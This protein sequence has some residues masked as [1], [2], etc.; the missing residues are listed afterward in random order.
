MM[1]REF[2]ENSSSSSNIIAG[3]TVSTSGLVVCVIISTK[4]QFSDQFRAKNISQLIK[5]I[6]RPLLSCLNALMELSF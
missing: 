5:G 4:T 6:S 1:V 3:I 2:C